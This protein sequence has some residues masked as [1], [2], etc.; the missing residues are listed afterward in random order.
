MMN[1]YGLKYSLDDALKLVINGRN[2]VFLITYT[3]MFRAAFKLSVLEEL[4]LVSFN[5]ERIPDGKS[6]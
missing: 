2:H 6:W 3:N 4:L 1:L 5:S